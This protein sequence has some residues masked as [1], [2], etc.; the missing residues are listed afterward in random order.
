MQI[1]P[2]DPTERGRC[3]FCEKEA[4]VIIGNWWNLTAMSG[5]ETWAWKVAKLCVEHARQHITEDIAS[6]LEDVGVAS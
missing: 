3:Q 6:A 2:I 4:D 1:K 5:K